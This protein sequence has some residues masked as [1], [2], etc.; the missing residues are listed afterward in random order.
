MHLVHL[1]LADRATERVVVDDDAS[2]AA[3]FS[4]RRE[5]CRR[6]KTTEMK[7]E[8]LNNCPVRDGIP[9]D[10]LLGKGVDAVG[11]EEAAPK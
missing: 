9:D 10:P 4:R 11:C 3:F 5:K 8:A 7:F 6:Q 1:Q 2:N